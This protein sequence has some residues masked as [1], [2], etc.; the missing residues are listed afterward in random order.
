MV[1]NQFLYMRDQDE[2]YGR[3][4]LKASACCR[5]PVFSSAASAAVPRQDTGLGQIP[6][7]P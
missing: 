3:S 1:L 7:L 6:G 4:R 2:I 5:A